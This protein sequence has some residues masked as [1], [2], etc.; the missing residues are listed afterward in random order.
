M[1][2]ALDTGYPGLERAA[3]EQRDPNRGLRRA[4]GRTPANSPLIG[5]Q[6]KP[7][8]SCKRSGGALRSSARGL[9]ATATKIAGFAAASAPSASHWTD[10]SAEPTCSAILP[11]DSCDPT[12][13][14]PAPKRPRLAAAGSHGY[15]LQ[16]QGGWRG[17]VSGLGSAASWDSD[18]D[19]EG[20]QAVVSCKH[21]TPQKAARG[22]AGAAAAGA[23]GAHRT[24]Q[25]PP[26]TWAS[27]MLASGA[28]ALANPA[29]AAVTAHHHLEQVDSDEAACM[30]GC[31]DVDM[32]VQ[33]EGGGAHL[34]S[35]HLATAGAAA[36]AAA[37]GGSHG[38]AAFSDMEDES[39]EEEAGD[40]FEGPW[41]RFDYPHQLD[42]E[43]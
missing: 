25:H 2:Q 33:Q 34:G 20:E 21:P 12:V 39:E 5:R 27:S 6:E 9:A 10:A 8:T 7:G 32:E 19:S 30:H 11:A 15:G 38:E 43:E 3:Q 18:S 26:P 28:A 1:H 42:V 31:M 29:A 41:L 22:G 17:A 16:Q 4:S 13:D 37:D 24:A 40:S 35:T 36:A 14:G 23:G